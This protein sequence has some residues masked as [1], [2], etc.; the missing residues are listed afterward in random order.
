MIYNNKWIKQ[1]N[2]TNETQ[3]LEKQDKDLLEKLTVEN[4]YLTEKLKE[5]KDKAAKQLNEMNS[6]LEG[7][8]LFPVSNLPI[9]VFPSN[10]FSLRIA[11]EAKYM[12]IVHDYQ[13]K[14]VVE[15]IVTRNVNK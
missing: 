8:V 15:C 13:R 6:F 10:D 11:I 4:Q 14:G 5:E 7:N 1:M 2:K 3:S 9:I 12:I